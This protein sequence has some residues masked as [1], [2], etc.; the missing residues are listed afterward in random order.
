MQSLL[1]QFY[2]RIKGSQEDVASES[3]TYILKKSVR[4]RQAINQ[5]IN[6]NTGLK[7]TDL[8]YQTQKTGVKLEKPD[9]S[10]TD[11]NGKEVLLIEAK[12]WA[13]LTDNQPNGYLDR[14]SENTLLMFLAPTLRVRAIYDEVLRRVKENNSI[15]IKTDIENFKIKINQSNKYIIIKSWNEILNL[16]KSE[17]LQENNQ[18]LVS[19]IDQIIGFCDTIDNNSFQ[20]IIDTDLSPS[21]A[22]KINSYYDIVDKVVDEIK[23]RNKNASTKGLHKAKSKYAYRRYFSIGNNGF[24]LGFETQLWAEYAD[25]PFWISIVENKA[26]WENSDKFI[27]ICEKIAFKLNFAFVEKNKNISFSLPPILN[28]TEDL[29]INDLAHKIELIY[30]EIDN[31]CGSKN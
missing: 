1:G 16:I 29:V 27:R 18:N 21:I 4:T 8:H 13:S 2:N 22:K 6:Q 5:I 25:T 23:N 7:F 15:E 26:N 11:K 19:D 17:L 20:P 9:I 3:L 12:F 28:K 14:L 31:Q 24:G 10:G 30:T